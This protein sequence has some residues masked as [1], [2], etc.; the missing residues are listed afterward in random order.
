MAEWLGQT[1]AGM[2]LWLIIV[3]VSLVALVGAVIY[4]MGYGYELPGPKS[5]WQKSWYKKKEKNHGK[6]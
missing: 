1:L 2:P 6:K 3:I 4:T 5:E